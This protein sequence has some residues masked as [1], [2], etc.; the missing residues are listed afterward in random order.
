[1]P[2]MVAGMWVHLRACGKPRQVTARSY[3]SYWLKLRTSVCT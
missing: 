2:G 1:V 3:V